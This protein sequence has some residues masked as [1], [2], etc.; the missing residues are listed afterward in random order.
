[1]VGDGRQNKR[2]LVIKKCSVVSNSGIRHFVILDLNFEAK[3][4]TD[5]N[6]KENCALTKPPHI[7]ADDLT[8]L[9]SFGNSIKETD[10]I[11]FFVA[12]NR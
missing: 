2:I 9:V 7:S 8:T 6:S 10:I 4:Y 1:M 5:L 3:S 12:L 11:S